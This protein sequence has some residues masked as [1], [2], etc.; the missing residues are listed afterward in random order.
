MSFISPNHSEKVLFENTF[1]LSKKYINLSKNLEKQNVLIIVRT[2]EKKKT[3]T[4]YSSKLEVLIVE[5]Y[6]QVKVYS[7]EANKPLPK[8][9]NET[10]FLFCSIDL[11]FDRFKNKNLMFF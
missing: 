9:P 3:L 2:G 1:D 6:A 10:I 4:Y 5:N 8:V 7:K 11:I